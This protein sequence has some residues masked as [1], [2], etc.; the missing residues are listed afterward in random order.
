MH[1][2]HNSQ[3][4]SRFDL[5]IFFIIEENAIKMTFSLKNL[6]PLISIL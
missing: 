4:T 2:K 5:L 1:F 6:F 3:Q